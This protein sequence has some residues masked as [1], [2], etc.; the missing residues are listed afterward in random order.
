[1]SSR[2]QPQFRHLAKSDVQFMRDMTRDELAAWN[3]L[4]AGDLTPFADLMETEDGII[5]PILQRWLVK[6]IK[7]SAIDTDYRLTANKHPDLPRVTDGLRH[8]RI[9]ALSTLRTA[10]IVA[11][12]GG[13]EPGQTA[14]AFQAAMD[15]TGLQERQVKAHWAK[16][17]TFLRV[18]RANGL[19]GKVKPR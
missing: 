10:Q 7:G 6:L 12:N 14:G 3:G 4:M 1:M 5:H 16:H 13:F 18:M 2:V 17:K 8:Q 11:Q 15:A 9:A 19:G